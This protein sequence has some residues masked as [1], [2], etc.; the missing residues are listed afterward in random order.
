MASAK[1][2]I[3]ERYALKNALCRNGG[4]LPMGSLSVGLHQVKLWRIPGHI[5]VALAVIVDVTGGVY[6]AGAGAD[7]DWDRAKRRAVEEAALALLCRDGDILP[8]QFTGM[9]TFLTHFGITEINELQSLQK[10]ANDD[11][12]PIEV[13]YA[14]ACPNHWPRQ[15]RW[16][17]RA[18]LEDQVYG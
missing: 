15:G 6:A 16:V 9:E 8:G 2:E 4:I 10:T 13:F 12:S 18:V 14:Q 11:P 17:M 1:K 7:I 3:I 5:P